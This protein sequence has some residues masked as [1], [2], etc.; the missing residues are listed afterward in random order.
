MK[1]NERSKEKTASPLLYIHPRHVSQP[2][3]RISCSQWLPEKVSESCSMLSGLKESKMEAGVHFLWPPVHVQIN[4]RSCVFFLFLV[5]NTPSCFHS[6]C[7]CCKLAWFFGMCCLFTGNEWRSLNF[8]DLG[9]KKCNWIEIVRW[10]S[11]WI[12]IDHFSIPCLLG[13]QTANEQ[14]YVLLSR[15]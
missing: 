11:L 14:R 4:P 5:C 7:Y 13:F 2:S 12:E 3:T 1:V 8:T 9:K 6:L 15:T 10:L